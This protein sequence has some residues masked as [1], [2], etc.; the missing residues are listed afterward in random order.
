MNRDSVLCGVA[1]LG[2]VVGLGAAVAGAYLVVRNLRKKSKVSFFLSIDLRVLINY[3]I[4]WTHPFPLR[5]SFGI[6]VNGSSN[7]YSSG[8]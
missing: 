5:S 2:A 4:T 6:E 3:F 7:C 8:S 1:G